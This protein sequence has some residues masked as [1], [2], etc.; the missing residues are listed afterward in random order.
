VGKRNEWR[1]K[2]DKKWRKEGE[3]RGEDKGK[4]EEKI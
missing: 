4:K 1:K 3:M 2:G